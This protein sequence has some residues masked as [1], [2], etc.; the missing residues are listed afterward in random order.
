MDWVWKPGQNRCDKVLI[1]DPAVKLCL[2]ERSLPLL[3]II[4]LFHALLHIPPYQLGVN[5][6]I[7]WLDIF[8]SI[9]E[10]P[11]QYMRKALH[12]EEGLG[13]LKLGCW[14]IRLQCLPTD[15]KIATTVTCNPRNICLRALI[16]QHLHDILIQGNT[17]ITSG[18][19]HLHISGIYSKTGA[20]V[21]R[22]VEKIL[23]IA[24]HPKVVADYYSLCLCRPP[25]NRPLHRLRICGYDTPRQFWSPRRAKPRFKIVCQLVGT[26]MVQQQQWRKHL[27]HQG[28]YISLKL[29][30]LWIIVSIR[31][32]WRELI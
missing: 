4:S 25:N 15:P 2:P 17:I 27:C 6:T 23:C 28:K 18:G 21:R 5:L 19:Q 10:S 7:V 11:C 12:G 24:T 29:L 3:A 14:C 13:W 20:V 1:P 9:L 30:L 22:Q 16:I 8:H 31:M 26:F 32:K